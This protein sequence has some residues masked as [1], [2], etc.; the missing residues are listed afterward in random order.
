[1]KQCEHNFEWGYTIEPVVYCT[2]C[3]KEITDIFPN[4]SYK[5]IEKLVEK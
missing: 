1:M 2:I 4:I 3:D 5:Y